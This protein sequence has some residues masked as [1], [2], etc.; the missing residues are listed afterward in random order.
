VAALPHPVGVS[1]GLALNAPHLATVSRT[2][3]TTPRR[4]VWKIAAASAAAALLGRLR[5]T[6]AAGAPRRCNSTRCTRHEACCPI[7]DCSGAVCMSIPGC[8]DLRSD[9]FHCGSCEQECDEDCCK[10]ECCFPT[11][12]QVCL[13]HGCGCADHRLSPCGA[14]CVN[15][16]TDPFNCGACSTFCPAGTVCEDGQCTS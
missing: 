5:P 14:N 16:Q 1:P 12:G 11:G 10:G 2:L 13:P 9:P 15:L 7:F 6:P 3:A 8:V 4:Q